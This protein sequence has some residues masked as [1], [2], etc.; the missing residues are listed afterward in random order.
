MKH[1]AN[2]VLRFLPTGYLLWSSRE[3]AVPLTAD[4]RA[5]ALSH[6]EKTAVAA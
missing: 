2:G 4:M 3:T 6:L 1:V 5:R